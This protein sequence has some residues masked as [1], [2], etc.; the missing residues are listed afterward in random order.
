MLSALAFFLF[1]LSFG[2]AGGKR[3]NRKGS[4]GWR[5]R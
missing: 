3:K 4:D 1:K 2:G 5:W